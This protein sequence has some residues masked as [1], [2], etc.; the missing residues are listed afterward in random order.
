MTV[1]YFEGTDPSVLTSLIC[2]G[3]NTI[4]I[5]N[6]LDNHG[7]YVRLLNEVKK[8]D[9]LLGY[10]HKIVAPASY[11]TQAEDVFHICQTYQIDF[12]VIVPR[13]LHDCARGRFTKFPEV[14]QF[15]DPGDLLDTARKV[16][17]RRREEK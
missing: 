15:V 6:G 10:M 11:E 2:D 12:L 14:V 5:S 9:L 16:L 3:C 17:A 4:P 7:Q 13:S 1:G 8:M